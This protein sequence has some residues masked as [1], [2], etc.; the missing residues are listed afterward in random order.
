[1]NLFL[2]IYN[3]LFYLSY[4]FRTSHLLPSASVL[5]ML[6]LKRDS[7][8]L[9]SIKNEESVS[10]FVCKQKLNYS[11]DLS[12]YIVQR[13]IP[14]VCLISYVVKHYAYWSSAVLSNIPVLLNDWDY[15]K[16]AWNVTCSF[17]YVCAINCND[18]ISIFFHTF[19]IYSWR[20][21][22]VPK[23]VGR[24][25]MTSSCSDS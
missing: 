8:T 3:T 17:M 25:F 20:F 16:F 14:P 13:Y 19:F 1:M 22:C 18:F 15:I 5:I 6:P 12:D 21:G 10:M 11:Y 9:W 7:N 4:E 2:I 23:V 24:S